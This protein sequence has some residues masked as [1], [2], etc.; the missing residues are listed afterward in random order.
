MLGYQL[1]SAGI[2]TAI[3]EKHP[4]FLRDVRGDTIHPSTMEIL[5]ERG[6]LKDFLKLPHYKVEGVRLKIG[7][8]LITLGDLTH[9]KVHAPYIAFT[10]QW[11]FLNFISEKGRA[12][13]EF[14]LMMDTAV[15]GLIEEDG[16]VVGVRA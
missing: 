7:D 13:K 3:L 4:D 15:T 11:D 1:A 16:R 2:E 9:L 12:Y 5:Y 8:E 10:P 14:N 6:L